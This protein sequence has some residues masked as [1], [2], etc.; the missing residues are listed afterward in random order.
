M[1]SSGAWS[2]RLVT[3]SSFPSISRARESAFID[4]V[5]KEFGLEIDFDDAGESC[6]A[7]R[8]IE[9]RLDTWA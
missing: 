7:D 5:G 1:I 4:L 2:G 9:A 3:G 6:L 8:V